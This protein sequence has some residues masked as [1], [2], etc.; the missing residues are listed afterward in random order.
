MSRYGQTIKFQGI[1]CMIK[2]H[3]GSIAFWHIEI[4]LRYED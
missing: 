2:K 4:L 1:G 3:M